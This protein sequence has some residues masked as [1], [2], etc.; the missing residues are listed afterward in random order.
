MRVGRS[1]VQVGREVREVREVKE[2]KEVKEVEEWLTGW[3]ARL[4]RNCKRGATDTAADA[5]GMGE[6]RK[7]K[8]RKKKE[9][10]NAEFGESAEKRNQE[11]RRKPVLQGW[12]PV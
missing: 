3:I 10:V 1:L 6:G 4:G 9:R 5:L 11:H 12:W 7:Q 8:F 2:V